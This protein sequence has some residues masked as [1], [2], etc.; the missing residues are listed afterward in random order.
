MKLSGFADAAE[1]PPAPEL[2][3]DREQILSM[4]A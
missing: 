1:F 3:A 4:L 2:D